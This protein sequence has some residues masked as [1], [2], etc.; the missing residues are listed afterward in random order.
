MYLIVFAPELMSRR[1]VWLPSVP[2]FLS[3]MDLV[4]S[5]S[6]LASSGRACVG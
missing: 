3:L 6:L 1:L 5:L 2:R 4:I